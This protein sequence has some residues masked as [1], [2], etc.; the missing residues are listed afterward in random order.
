MKDILVFVVIIVAWIALN[1]WIL[2]WFGVH[3]C[4][5]GACSRVPRAETLESRKS[6]DM[7]G[8]DGVG[9][10]DVPNSVP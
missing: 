7:V 4:M 9:S 1:L 3:T 6:T 2:P 10:S 8:S 5:S